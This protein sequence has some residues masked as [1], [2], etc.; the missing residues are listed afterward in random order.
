[1]KNHQ[2]CC[3]LGR[4]AFPRTE[5]SYWPQRLT[6]AILRSFYPITYRKS[7]SGDAASTSFQQDGLPLTT[8]SQVRVLPEELL[9]APRNWPPRQLTPDADLAAARRFAFTAFP[10]TVYAHPPAGD[11][12][13]VSRDAD[14]GS[15]PTIEVGLGPRNLGPK[16][17]DS[18]IN[19]G[20]RVNNKAWFGG[21]QPPTLR[22]AA[23][24]DCNS[25]DVIEADKRP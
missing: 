18:L 17:S 8:G 14:R 3:R 6:L 15:E 2:Q 7:A 10:A 12:L 1:M 19:R 5:L 20:S 24:L 22:P 16:L 23:C 13:S 11:K 21:R 25:V 9:F 4:R